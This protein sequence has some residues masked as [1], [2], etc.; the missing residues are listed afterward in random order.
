MVKGTSFSRGE[1]YVDYKSKKKGIKFNVITKLLIEQGFLE[2]KS[3]I[4]I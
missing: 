4:D 2:L 3:Q 1:E